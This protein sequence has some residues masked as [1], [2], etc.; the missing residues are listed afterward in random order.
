MHFRGILSGAAVLIAGSAVSYAQQ[1]VLPA[2]YATPSVN[3]RPQVIAPPADAKLTT[4]AGFQVEILQ[5]GSKQPRFMLL[6]PRNEGLPGATVRGNG[7]EPGGV[8]YVLNGKE[9]KPIL[10]NLLSPYGLAIQNG[11]LYVGEPESIKRYKYD[12][13]TQT[14]SG[15]GQEIVS[16]KGMEQGHWRRCLLLICGVTKLLAADGSVS[17]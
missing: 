9:R 10:Q 8:I 7:R 17:N 5:E 6:G 4:P 13:K 16:L 2:P 3:N 12:T 15:E 1:K 11:Y 14:V